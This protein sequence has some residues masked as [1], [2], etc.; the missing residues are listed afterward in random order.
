ML[1]PRQAWLALSATFPYRGTQ[2]LEPG[3][4]SVNVHNVPRFHVQPVSLTTNGPNATPPPMLSLPQ[5]CPSCSKGSF[6][7]SEDQ[8]LFREAFW[9]RR[10]MM[11]CTWNVLTLT[12][13]G[14]R[15]ECFCAP[16]NFH[17][18]LHKLLRCAILAHTHPQA[19]RQFQF[20]R[21]DCLERQLSRHRF[22]PAVNLL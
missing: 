22:V 12:A 5:S 18:S 14:K 15:P 16:V 4:V 1:P 7:E 3:R 6:P 13:R 9:T 19:D 11:S 21:G 2:L 8:P 20:L 17:D 10:E